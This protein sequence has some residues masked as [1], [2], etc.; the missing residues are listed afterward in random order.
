MDLGLDGARALIGGGSGGLG[1]PSG[2]RWRPR[3][4]GSRSWRGRRTKLDARRR[5]RGRAAGRRGPLDRGRPGAGRRRGPSTRSA[6]S[7]SCS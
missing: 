2:R 4:L 1:W 6:G 7:T 3:A 5:D